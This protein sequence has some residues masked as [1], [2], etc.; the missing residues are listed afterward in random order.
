MGADMV[1]RGTEFITEFDEGLSTELEDQVLAKIEDAAST[2]A[3]EV[4]P[5]CDEVR[6]VLYSLM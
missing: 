6:C 4:A 1:T 5:D 3:E 2:T